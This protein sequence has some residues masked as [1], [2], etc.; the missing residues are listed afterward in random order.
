MKNKTHSFH[1]RAGDVILHLLCRIK[2]SLMSIVTIEMRKIRLLLSRM[3][4]SNVTCT[5]ANKRIHL[6]W[7]NI[8]CP[9]LTKGKHKRIREVERAG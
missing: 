5:G 1:L 7:Y 4:F 6:F 9:Q 8:C 3:L 2:Y